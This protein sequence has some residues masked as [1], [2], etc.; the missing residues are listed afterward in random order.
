MFPVLLF[1]SVPMPHSVSQASSSQA[2]QVPPTTT[3]YW[4]PLKVLETNRF[5]AH[6]RAHGLRSA[7]RRL[8]Y[9]LGC[10]AQPDEGSSLARGI[11]TTCPA[12]YVKHTW[13]CGHH[14]NN[15]HGPESAA[16][17]WR[18]RRDDDRHED[19]GGKSAPKLSEA[20]VHSEVE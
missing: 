15:H 8:S 17:S 2:V 1:R 20:F 5:V 9:C 6:S 13:A 11:W 16:S 10:A 3:Y 4:R 7:L 19:R 18:S 14:N 12:L